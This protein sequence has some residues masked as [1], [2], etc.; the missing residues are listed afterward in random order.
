LSAEAVS[1]DNVY[2]ATDDRRIAAVVSEFG[3]KY[4]MTS[5]EALTG[6]DRVA[7]VSSKVDA[8]LYINVQGDE[9]LV[10]PADICKV[11]EIKQRYMDCV[12]NA[13]TVIGRDEN[14]N[15]KNVPKVVV[16]RNDDLIYMSRCRVPGHK[17]KPTP[18]FEYKKQVCI[19]AFTADELKKFVNFGGKGLAEQAE[20]IEILRFL[21][22]GTKVKM[23][24]LNSASL[25][26]D[27]PDDVP[28]V[29]KELSQRVNG[30]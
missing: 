22:M 25:A 7:E 13:Y 15:S 5:S 30:T 2:V 9:P 16:S 29:E 17:G 19:Y 1:L 14:P 24:S 20:D 18:N 12:I 6:T 23:V 4:L 27:C 10:N 28:S 11:I 8:D 26:V 21:E 3:F